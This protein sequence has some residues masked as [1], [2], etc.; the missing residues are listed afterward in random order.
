MENNGLIVGKSGMKD[1]KK[2]IYYE[3]TEAGEFLVY[4]IRDSY[5]IIADTSQ[6]S[7][8]RDFLTGK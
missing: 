6:G 7:M 4:Y 8:F 2:V 3:I 5:Q 1:N